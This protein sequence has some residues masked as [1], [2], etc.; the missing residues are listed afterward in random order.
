MTQGTGSAMA[1]NVQTDDVC[2]LL[3]PPVRLVFRWDGDRW[4]HQIAVG[5]A[6]LASSVEW[7]VDHGDPNR[8][9]SPA[10]QQIAAPGPPV[11]VV[12]QWGRHHFSGVFTL[13]T[14]DRRVIVEVDTAVRTRAPLESLGS[15][16]RVYLSSSDLTSADATAVE[17]TLGPPHP[18]RLRFEPG[19]SDAGPARVDLAEAGRRETRVQV[20]API[21]DGRATHRLRYRWTWQSG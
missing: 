11:L 20:V 14:E 7:D 16:Y 21:V 17:W 18:G 1:E 19:E 8:V 15:T 10:F 12:G 9:V 5:D 13:T 3:A 2:T 4:T 6:V